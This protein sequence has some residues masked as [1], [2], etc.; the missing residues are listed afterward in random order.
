[1]NNINR[2]FAAGLAGAML[3]TVLVAP[4]AG[5]A[6]KAMTESEV[7]AAGGKQLQ[8]AAIK[9]MNLGNTVYTIFLKKSG[10]IA[11]GSVVPIYHRDDRTRVAKTGV[12][13]KL[14]ANWWIDGNSYCNEQR[15]VNVGHQCYTIWDLSGTLYSC[16]QPAGDCM[17]SQRVVPGNPE[18]L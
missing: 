5:Q 2:A 13:Q 1:M 16:L 17:F 12:T 4:A 15:L 6:I 18:N 7:K 3:A 9:Q 8:G 10:N 11:A 14:E